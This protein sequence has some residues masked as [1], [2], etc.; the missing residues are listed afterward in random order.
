MLR[1]A[2]NSAA[3]WLVIALA[4]WTGI[5]SCGAR[6]SFGT[7]LIILPMLAL[8]VAVPT[9]G[10][11]GTYHGAMK[12]GL[13]LFGVA[14]TLA[15]SAALLMHAICIVPIVV[16]GLILLWT[17]RISWKEFIS[18]ARQFKDLGREMEQPTAGKTL[19]SMP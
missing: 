12:F 8:G 16:L 6:I 5:W 14:R 13:M 11:V 4:T 17:E 10:G 1:I 9:P 15:V 19:E 3:A 18:A 2:V 7:V